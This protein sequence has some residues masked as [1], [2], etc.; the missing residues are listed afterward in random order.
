MLY[1][2]FLRACTNAKGTTEPTISSSSSPLRWNK[3]TSGSEYFGI[4]NFHSTCPGTSHA[5]SQTS[6][7]GVTTANVLLTQ[8]RRGD[9]SPPKTTEER[10]KSHCRLPL[11]ARCLIQ[12]EVAKATVSPSWLELVTHMGFVLNQ[13]WHYQKKMEKAQPA[14]LGAV[15]LN[16]LGPGLWFPQ[17]SGPLG[18][19][20][21]QLHW[22]HSCKSLS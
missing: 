7:L 2:Q 12:R 3:I 14:P 18:R 10:G 4:T 6:A 1:G 11:P 19:A 21:P 16:S 5:K 13:Y 17:L 15:A 8:G 20:S 9:Y 22:N